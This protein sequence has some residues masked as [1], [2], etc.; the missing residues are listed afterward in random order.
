M[1]G[2]VKSG[3]SP[4]G[5]YSLVWDKVCKQTGSEA[6]FKQV[7]SSMA[8]QSKRDA[9]EMPMGK[10]LAFSPQESSWPLPAVVMTLGDSPVHLQSAISPFPQPILH[11]ETV[12]TPGRTQLRASSPSQCP[13]WLPIDFNKKSPD[14]WAWYHTKSV[15]SVI[16]CPQPLFLI[17]LGFGG[18]FLPPATVGAPGSRLACSHISLLFQD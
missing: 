18:G 6:L 15:P 4:K 10:K 5:V 17:L 12:G 11:T 16:C 1:G 2:F 7:Q 3:S 9:K 13:W 8:E 14:P